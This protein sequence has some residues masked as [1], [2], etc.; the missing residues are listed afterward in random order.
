MSYLWAALTTDRR[1][2]EAALGGKVRVTSYGSRGQTLTDT[3]RA[4]RMCGCRSTT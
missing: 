4:I 1:N 2:V 3:D